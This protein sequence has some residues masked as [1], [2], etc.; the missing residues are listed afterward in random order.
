MAATREDVTT[1]VTDIHG[2][3]KDLTIFI[4]DTSYFNVHFQDPGGNP[5]DISNSLITC[6]INTGPGDKVAITLSSANTEQIYVIDSNNSIV[7]FKFKSEKSLGFKEEIGQYKVIL[8]DQSNTSTLF[9]K[10][11]IFFIDSVFS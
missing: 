8:T 2:Y 6:N 10:G 9:L 3:N 7:Q 1:F 5:I 4:G 11:K